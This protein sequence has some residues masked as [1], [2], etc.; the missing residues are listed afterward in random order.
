MQNF[1]GNNWSSSKIKPPSRSY[2]ADGRRRPE[3]NKN[4]EEEE[5]DDS[6]KNG[7]DIPAVNSDGIDDNSSEKVGNSSGRRPLIIPM[8]NN[9]RL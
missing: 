6:S 1:A 2:F 7:E 5:K 8:E 4:D 9:V 3:N